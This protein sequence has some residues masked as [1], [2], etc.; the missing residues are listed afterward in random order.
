[1]QGCNANDESWKADTEK[2]LI[3]ED[4]ELMRLCGCYVRTLIY[5]THRSI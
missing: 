2:I 4:V 5:V 3:D 1:M